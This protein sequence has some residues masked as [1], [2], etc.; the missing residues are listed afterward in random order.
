[1]QPTPEEIKHAYNNYAESHWTYH[2]D[3]LASC[4]PMSHSLESFTQACTLNKRLYN[5][6]RN[7]I[8]FK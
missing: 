8:P 7:R 1:M 5:K 6:W 2:R 4:I 3:G